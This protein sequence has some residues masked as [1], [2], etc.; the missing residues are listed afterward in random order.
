MANPFK[1]ARFI[2]SGGIYRVNP[3]LIERIWG[4]GKIEIYSIRHMKHKV[5]RK[6]SSADIVFGRNFVDFIK[7]YGT[8]D[9]QGVGLY[10]IDPSLIDLILNIIDKKHNTKQ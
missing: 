2:R 6:S 5:I 1:R 9:A 7:H 3:Y 8:K 4:S 10:N